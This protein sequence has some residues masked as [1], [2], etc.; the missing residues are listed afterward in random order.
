MANINSSFQNFENNILKARQD[1]DSINTL[2][3]IDPVVAN[4]PKQY[5]EPEM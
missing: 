3:E 1:L 5:A 4:L 2:S